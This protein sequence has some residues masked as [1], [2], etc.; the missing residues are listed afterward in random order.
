MTISPRQLLLLD[1]NVLIH[2]A[3]NDAIGQDIETRYSL[4]HRPEPPLLST[5][6]EGELLSFAY[7]RQWGQ[8]KIQRLR[9]LLKNLVRVDAGLPK[10]VECYAQLSALARSQGKTMGQNDLLDCR[11]RSSGGR[12]AFDIGSGFPL[13][14]S[15]LHPSN[16]GLSS[17]FAIFHNSLY[18]RK[19][20]AKVHLF[21]YFP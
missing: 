15:E 4:T 3:R 21:R 9:S 11:Y 20:Q 7:Y 16:P 13:A 5:I 8:E 17:T 12:L 6:V 19:L 18:F 14:F 10:V 1:T 2:L